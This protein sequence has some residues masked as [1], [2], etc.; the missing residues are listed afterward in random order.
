MTVEE[1]QAALSKL[2]YKPGPADGDLGPSTKRAVRLFQRR[3]GLRVDGDPGP[4]TQAVIARFL[5]GTIKP[6]PSPTLAPAPAPVHKLDTVQERMRL[7]MG[8]LQADFKMDRISAAGILGNWGHESGLRPTAK[9]P[10]GDTGL[11]QWTGSRRRGL[12]AY[13]KRYGQ[14]PMALRT[15]YE[16]ARQELKGAYAGAV[17]AVTRPGTLMSKV[18]RFERAYEQAGVKNYSSRYAWALRALKA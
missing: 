1:I 4:R 2:G 5:P 17:R 16:Y 10:A 6:A 8:W 13:A 15:Q 11:A 12:Y 7:L 18:Q 9:G 3:H 14:D